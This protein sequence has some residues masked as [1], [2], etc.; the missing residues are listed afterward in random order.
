[1]TNADK[2]REFFRLQ[3]AGDYDEGFA[4][5]AHPDFR[6]VV[7]SRD[8]DALRAAIPWAGYTHEGRAGY[9]GLYNALF[10]EYDVETFEPTA[11]T[12]AA[13]GGKVYV[14][15]H[16]RF[17][18]KETGK[19]ADSDWCARFDMRDGRIAGGQFFENTQAVADARRS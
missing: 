4:R 6:F 5:Y 17:R 2:V 16:F 8:N 19:I 13:D 7:A 3:Y 11:F 14:E 15:G 1:M 10:G 9:E 18:H 12:E